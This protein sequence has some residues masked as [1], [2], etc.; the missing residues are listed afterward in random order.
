MAQAGTV[1]QIGRH[2]Y[3]WGDLLDISHI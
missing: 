1:G 3:E 2:R